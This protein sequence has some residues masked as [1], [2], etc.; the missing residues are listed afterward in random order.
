[1]GTWDE[2]QWESSVDSGVPRRER[3]SGPYRRYVPDLLSGAPLALTP[4]VDA[5]VARAERRVRELGSAS[6]D[7]AGIS[8]FLLRS[9]AIASSRIEGIAPSARQVALAELG[10]SEQVRGVSAQA[11]LVANNMTVVR[12]ATTRL[13]RAETVTVDDVVSLHASL[14]PD[15]PRHHGLRAVQNW[16]G[17][18][19]WHPLEADF[20]PPPAERVPHLMSDLLDYLAGAVHSPLVQ[21]ALVHAQFETI[22]PFT[23]GNGRVGRALIHTVLA[24][25]GLVDDAVLPVSLVLSTLKDR[26]VDGLTDFRRAGG[27]GSAMAGRE[28]WVSTFAEVTLLACD[29]ADRIGDALAE[30]RADW[31]ERVRIHRLARGTMRAPRAD[32]ATSLILL[33]LPATPVLTVA[34]VQRI[35]GVSHV[36]AGRALDELSEAGILTRKSIAPGRHAYVADDVLDLV[37][38]AE[39]RLASTR[40]DTREAP[41]HEGV[42]RAPELRD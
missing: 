26:Y 33:D 16:I 5:L 22:H 6:R 36:A 11:Q 37:T 7:L 3:R 38:W 23:D 8:R 31:Q 39:R 41:P 35:H 15:E 34:T 20:V 14:L 30:V 19:G 10:Q 24:R 25:R 2:A 29:Q 42:A 1:M 28:A 18:S 9:E 4:D 32:S 12:E 21:A 40:F 27:P 17:G 13:V